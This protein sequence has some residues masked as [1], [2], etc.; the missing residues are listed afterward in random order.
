MQTI[1]SNSSF[2]SKQIIWKK[3]RKRKLNSLCAF[4]ADRRLGL[5]W[6]IK[7]SYLL[8]ASVM[9][10]WSITVSSLFILTKVPRLIFKINSWCQT[11]FYIHRTFQKSDSISDTDTSLIHKCTSL[12]FWPSHRRPSEYFSFLHRYSPRLHLW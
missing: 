10:N 9:F 5:I 2:Y 4:D 7:N 8:K 1:F 6:L 11:D 3:K 12:S